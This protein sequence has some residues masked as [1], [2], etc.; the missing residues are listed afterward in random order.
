MSHTSSA[1]PRTL[2]DV[3][4]PFIE[5]DFD[6][7]T[8]FN[9]EPDTDDPS[10]SSQDTS[11]YQFEPLGLVTQDQPPS[12]TS[13][14]NHDTPNL[15]RNVEPSAPR[16]LSINENSIKQNQ[17]KNGIEDHLWSFSINENVVTP[18]RKRQAFSPG[19]RSEVAMVRKIKACQRC[20]MRKLSASI[21][22]AC[23]TT[24]YPLTIH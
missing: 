10:F 21:H 8:F 15:L 22:L 6:W 20:K 19:R 12:L 5:N 17:A 7:D 9:F 13:G 3:Q 24:Y 11:I 4:L 1:S 2:D 18:P 23:M 14:T 16:Q